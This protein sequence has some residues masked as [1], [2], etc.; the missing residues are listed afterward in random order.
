MVW[1]GMFLGESKGGLSDN[2]DFFGDECK[3]DAKASF[4]GA[5]KDRNFGNKVIYR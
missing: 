3:K 5:T 4:D 2:Y 1:V